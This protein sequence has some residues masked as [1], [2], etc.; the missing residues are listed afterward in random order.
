MSEQSNG[1]LAA[2]AAV[3]AV[4]PEDG[5]PLWRDA[6]EAR[7]RAV[8]SNAVQVNDLDAALATLCESGRSELTQAGWCR[9]RTGCPTTLDLDAIDARADKAT[10]GPWTL[11]PT[12]DYEVTMADGRP[13]HATWFGSDAR[14]VAAARSDV[15]ALCAEVRRLR[16]KLSRA[17]EWIRSGAE[18]IE[19]LDGDV[20]GTCANARTFADEL[21]AD[22]LNARQATRDATALGVKFEGVADKLSDIGD[23]QAAEIQRLRQELWQER[24]RSEADEVT[25]DPRQYR[26]ELTAHEVA[27]RV[28]SRAIIAADDATGELL[29]ALL[30]SGV[31]SLVSEIRRLMKKNRS[32][33]GKLIETRQKLDGAW[34]S[35]ESTMKSLDYAQR[36]LEAARRACSHPVDDRAPVSG[37]G[38]V[39]GHC[40]AGVDAPPVVEC[41]DGDHDPSDPRPA[42]G[43]AVS[44]EG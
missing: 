25:L 36:Q 34:R 21:R 12:P 15:P 17:E 29:D 32:L 23:R 27:E 43:C 44:E 41:T 30:T 5:T 14:F 37:D 28:Q 10:V 24:A 26:W 2:E 9:I 16:R 13:L 35:G 20:D 31:P 7:L 4:L 11:G 40:G 38:W 33:H 42:N 39:C 19:M 3:L 8:S 18:K 22:L 6:I 1:E